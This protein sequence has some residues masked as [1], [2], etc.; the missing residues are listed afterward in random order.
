MEKVKLQVRHELVDPDFEGYKLSLEPLASFESELE[1][2]TLTARP[3]DDDQYSYLHSKLFSGNNAVVNDPFDDSAAYI[4]D[5]EQEAILQVVDRTADGHRPD[6][7]EVW[8]APEP[9]I[10]PGDYNPS[11]S[12]ASDGF[13]V[14]S[15]GRGGLYILKTGARTSTRGRQW[16]TVFNDQV[17]GP[18]RSFLVVA[19]HLSSTDKLLHVLLQYVEAKAKVEGL[20]DVPENHVNVVEWMSF[21]EPSTDPPSCITSWQLDR[22]RRFAFQGSLDYID[23]AKPVTTGFWCLT[24]KPFH[25]LFDSSGI[26]DEDI[27]DVEMEKPAEKEAEPPFYWMQGPEDMVVWVTLP[28]E[29]TKKDIKVV[30]KPSEN[31][32]C[33]QRSRGVW[34]KAVEHSGRRFDDLDDPKEQ[35]G[36]HGLQSQ[37]RHDLAKVFE[38]RRPDQRR[39][40][41]QRSQSRRLGDGSV[42]A[43]RGQRT[44]SAGIEQD[45]QRSG[46]RSLRR[47]AGRVFLHSL[48]GR[49]R[50]QVDASGQR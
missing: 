21:Q 33:D 1:G 9:S 36:D 13:A 50:R 46:A 32:G 48:R 15:D 26:T 31:E 38:A 23:L 19:S 11:L 18:Q 22:V 49:H 20:K 45:L 12:F 4:V 44:G 40:G 30:A 47:R 16:T 35:V 24:E 7:I 28:P 25:L 39:A 34:R 6:V 5:P 37:R 2:H 29:T 41:S 3:A 14:F 27:T 43:N 42:Q 8:S 17:S 10:H